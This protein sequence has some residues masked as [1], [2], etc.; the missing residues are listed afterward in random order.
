M[1]ARKILL[2]PSFITILVMKHDPFIEEN[3]ND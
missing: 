1:F 3:I 2:K